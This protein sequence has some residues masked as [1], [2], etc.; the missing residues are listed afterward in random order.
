MDVGDED[1]FALQPEGDE[2][3]ETGKGR[4]ARAGN[5]NLDVADVFA[6][7]LEPV[8]NRGGDDD[9]GAVLVIMEYRYFHALAQ[10]ALDDETF[11]RLDVFE[12]DAAKRRLERGDDVDD[13]IR[14]RRINFDVEHV[15]AGELL[16]KAGLAFHHRFA[17]EG[18]D[19]AKSQNRRA[20][21][22]HGHQVGARGQARG[23][24]RVVADG[25][26]GIGH[27]RR[28]GEREVVL[29]GEALG[30]R[31][32]YFSGDGSAMVVEGSFAKQFFIHGVPRVRKGCWQG[33]ARPR[34]C[35]TR[36]AADSGREALR[37]CP[38]YPPRGSDRA[39]GMPRAGPARRAG[40][41]RREL[42]ADVRN[43]G[44]DDGEDRP[45]P[46]AVTGGARA[47]PPGA[48]HCRARARLP[49]VLPQRQVRR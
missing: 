25:K 16:E 28:I 34:Y 31:D 5:G 48:S 14:L 30:W 1:V 43:G 32:G 17:G 24:L 10:L 35:L 45:G 36:A 4:R 38:P 3:I 41:W 23:L 44:R 29:V 40:P 21:A 46:G 18:T 7:Q 37:A 15:D 12:V 13:A 49:G 39:P 33:Q 47:P 42:R 8:Q 22:H 2:Q 9:G 20:I 11:R 19:V 6:D 26:A 27:A